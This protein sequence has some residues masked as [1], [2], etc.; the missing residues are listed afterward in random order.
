MGIGIDRDM[1]IDSDVAPGK[2]IDMDIESDVA[3]FI[4]RGSFKRD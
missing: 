2:D 4:T 3:L 1:D